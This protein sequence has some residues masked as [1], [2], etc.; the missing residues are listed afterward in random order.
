M[1]KILMI[2]LTVVMASFGQEDANANLLSNAGIDAPGTGPVVDDWTLDFSKTISGPTTDLLTLEPF[3]D[4]VAPA[5]QGGFFK[6]FQGDLGSGDLATAH[7]YQEVAGNAGLEYTFSGYAGSGAGFSGLLSGTVT[8]AVF[9]IEFDNDN[10]FGNGAISTSVVDL[11]ANGL[12]AGPGASFGYDQFS[13]SAIA[14]VGTTVV[15]VR[16]SMIDGYNNP[17]G[18]D[19]AFVIDDFSLTATAIPEPSSAI[20]I[21][22]AMAGLIRRRS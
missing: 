2:M 18:G 3:A 21:L 22:T 12:G 7:V 1:K 19:Q 8:Q 11:L 15:R 20:L 13:V 6:A 16:A 5:G 10:D 14:P 4:R 17:A 9:A